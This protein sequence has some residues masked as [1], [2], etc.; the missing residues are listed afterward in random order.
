MKPD[1][2]LAR[3]AEARASAILRTSDETKAAAAM[4]AAIRGGFR[5]V[6]F[7]LSIPNALGLI[8]EY[9]KRPDLVVGAGTVLTVEDA[10]RAVAAGAQFIVSPVVDEPVIAAAARLGVASVPGALTPTEM[11]RAHRAGATLIK[12]FPAPPS[13]PGY[14]KAILGPFP[15]FKIVPTTGA[16]ADNAAAFLEAGAFAIGFVAS[17][18]VADDVLGGHTDRIEERA[19]RMLAAVASARRR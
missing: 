1:E 7:T 10:E 17:L 16:D 13:G 8:R 6:E 2:F 19:R 3:V 18:F 11:L 9:R 12:L 4:D 5:V 14:V 15:D